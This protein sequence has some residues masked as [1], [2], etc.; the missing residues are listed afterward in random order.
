MNHLLEAHA[1][2]RT[3][4]LLS[5]FQKL[6]LVIV[7]EL[8]F[9]PFTTTGSELL[10]E[11]FSEAYERRTVAITTN[12]P[13]A[14]WTTIFGNERSRAALLD[15]LTHRCH[16]SEFRAESYRLKQ[17]LQRQA[18]K[19][20]EEAVGKAT[21]ED[22]AAED[23]LAWVDDLLCQCSNSLLCQKTARPHLRSFATLPDAGCI[24]D[25]QVSLAPQT[26]CQWAGTCFAGQQSRESGFFSNERQQ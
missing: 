3:M 15:R 19:A 2:N 14:E 21:T 1:Q 23:Q 9:V 5:S 22:L 11:F 10:F 6:D 7:D 13:F 26:G 20:E 4:Q 8:G 17:S 24:P 18:A 25:S 12:L 16:I